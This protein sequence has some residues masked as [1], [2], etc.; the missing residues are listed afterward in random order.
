MVENVVTW[1]FLGL[2]VCGH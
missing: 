1:F 2:G